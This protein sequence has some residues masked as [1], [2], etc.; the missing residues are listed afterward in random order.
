[1]VARELTQELR[2]KH[3][4][5]ARSLARLA[6]E[7]LAVPGL[8]DASERLGDFFCDGPVS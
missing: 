5:K 7:C 2:G 4:L 3:L 6:E 8:A 1:L